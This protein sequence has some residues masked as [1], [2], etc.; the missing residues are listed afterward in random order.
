L[1]GEERLTLKLAVVYEE[2]GACRTLFLPLKDQDHLK[3][4]WK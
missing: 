2:S 3:D 1:A 4:L